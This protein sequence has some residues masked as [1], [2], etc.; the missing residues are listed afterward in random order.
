MID[1]RLITN[2]DWRL[3]GVI[4]GILGIG[5][6]TLYSVTRHSDVSRSTV[7]VKQIY[8]VILGLGI[9]FSVSFLD[10]HMLVRYAFGF[11]GITLLLLIMVLFVGRVGQGAQRWL[12][13]GPFSFQPSEFAKLTMLL[14]MAKY[15][16]ENKQTGGLRF[17][18][19]FFPGVLLAIPT[20]LILRQPDLGTALTVTFIFLL[21]VGLVGFRSKNLVFGSILFFMSLPFLWHFF[22]SFLKEYQRERLLTFIDPSAD[23]MGAGYHIIQSKIAIGSGGILG[24]GYLSGTQ[25]QLKFLPEGHTDFIFS[26]FAEEWG[27]IGVFLLFSLYFVLIVM[28]IEIAAK[29]KDSL[30]V[31]LSYGVVGM[32][33]FYFMINIGMTL[34]VMPV[35][36]VPL[37][38][39]SYGGTSMVTMLAALG[40]LQ[41]VKIRRFQL[42]Y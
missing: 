11:Y 9:Y 20:V 6:L 7:F 26:V 23:P 34:G 41:S 33:S 39:M 35:V 14:V 24:K 12:S 5:L 10:Y 3:L 38:L 17:S 25:S 40:I 21:L 8:W 30:G 28:G 37:P 32:L 22:W 27:F 29:A 31:L 19:L 18:Q 4:L 42:F 15:F 16:S 2:F 13:L 36:G 1:R